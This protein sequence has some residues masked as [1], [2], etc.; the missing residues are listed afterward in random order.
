ME[1]TQLDILL[2]TRQWR[3]TPRGVELTLWG[4]SQRGPVRVCVPGQAAVCFVERGEDI[5]R[6]K[7]GSRKKIELATLAGRPVD[8]LYL[9]SQAELVAVRDA[10]RGRGGRL[11]ESDLKPHE[12]YLMER[13][14][15]VAA[16]ISG[17]CVQRSGYLEFSSPKVTHT[18]MP[19]ALREGLKVASVDIET[20]GASTRVISIAVTQGHAAEVFVVR[21]P[22]W[23][24]QTRL[25]GSVVVVDDEAALLR[26]FFA[27]LRELDPDVIIGWNIT[28][29]DLA[30]LH[31]R[32]AHCGV[33]F[34]MGRGSQRATVLA[35]QR[36]FARLPGR[37]VIDGIDTMKTATWSF[38]DYSLDAVANELL[39][40]SKAIDHSVDKVAE[41]DR[42]HREDPCALA[43]YNLQDCQLVAEI[44]DRAHLLEFA[45]RRAELTGLDVSRAGGSAAAFDN[46][47]L[48]KLHRMGWVAPDVGATAGE[49]SPGGYVL[50]SVPGMH[51]NVLVLD[52]KSLY[53]SIIRT[54]LIDPL[55]L[56]RGL[57][58]APEAAIA[59][60][61]GGSF[62]RSEHI[63]PGLI[64]Q[65]WQARDQAKINKDAPLSTAIKIIM[66]SFYGV[67]GSHGCRFFDPRLASSI[68][69]RGHEILMETR[70][71][72]E[73]RGLAVIYGDTDS[74]FVALG[75]GVSETEANEVGAELART[76]NEYWNERVQATFGVHSELEIE[77]ELLYQRFFMPTMRGSSKG[78]KKRYAGLL[79]GSDGQAQVRIVGLEAVRSDWTPLARRVQREVFRR[80]FVDQDVV[81]YLEGIA[82]QLR[83]G[84]LDEELVYRKRLRRELS[85]YTV[86]VPPHVQAARK[87]RRPG[88]WIR[89]VITT[90]GPEP[91]EGAIP[92]PDYD[93]YFSRQLAPVVDAILQ[94]KELSLAGIAGS[95]VLLF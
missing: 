89:Y 41:I 87:A 88:R 11:F 58:G 79:R 40:R 8:A 82:A 29:F 39:G 42:M 76:L 34:A 21:H 26:T 3:D 65:L 75:D 72:L 45:F 14:V 2:L 52:F 57:S 24:A 90:G 28:G 91:V 15:T 77:F 69:L 12:R 59:G 53:P 17:T 4:A 67:L 66:N 92:T 85:E 71:E 61:V 84:E 37:A 7:G 63:L 9:R 70:D 44:F 22:D 36:A 46:L 31:R 60:F 35:G 18:A 55:G 16:R 20:T 54:F 33:E 38:E 51:N 93:H 95:Q 13:F 78:S 64:A 25:A 80:V 49:L 30:V 86:N 56:H 74:V 50:D 81:G 47:Y 43:T 5:G 68:T 94:T 48:P 19:Q 83:R 62:S 27:R 23:P 1:P 32:S 10:V 73:R 6:L